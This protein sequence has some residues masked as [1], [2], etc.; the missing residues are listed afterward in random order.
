MAWTPV[1]LSLLAH[2]A[3]NCIL[4]VWGRGP[5]GTQGSVLC[6]W[7]PGGAAGPSPIVPFCRVLGTIRADP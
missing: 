5:R 2:C 7:S 4:G 1:L 6:P 3:G